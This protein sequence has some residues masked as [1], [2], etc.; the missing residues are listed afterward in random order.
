[1]KKQF[2]TAAAFRTSLEERL[3]KKA[4]EEKVDLNRLRKK[5]TFDRALARLFNSENSNWYLKGGY[6]IEL[7]AESAR[8]TKDIDISATG[9]LSDNDT[10][11]QLLL[12]ELQSR[13]SQ[14][15][16][17]FFEFNVSLGSDDV[18]GAPYGGLRFSVEARVDGRPFE[19]IA[20]DVGVGDYTLNPL[21]QKKLDDVLGFAGIDPPTIQLIRAEQQF[22]EKL[23]AYTTPPK[24]IVPNSR[25]KDLVDMV[26]LLRGKEMIAED[27][28]TTI[29]K[30]FARRKTHEFNPTLQPPPA[31]WQKPFSALAGEVG[32]ELAIDQAFE[33]LQAEINSIFEVSR[34]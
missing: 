32:L 25:V 19:T 30:T 24:G 1:M 28:K 2:S 8:A 13:F 29:G 12:Q 4:I 27:L 3:R 18:D 10:Q 15:L 31:D 22:A 6:S 23:H 16:N 34:G 5:V 21:V 33:E 26:I 7:R 11:N 17:D 14:D 9:S 20:V